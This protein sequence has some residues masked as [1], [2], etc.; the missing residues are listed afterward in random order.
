[1]KRS[2][3]K[4]RQRSASR[5]VATRPGRAVGNP[6]A[7]AHRPGGGGHLG[8]H[9]G[10]NAVTGFSGMTRASAHAIEHRRDADAARAR[11][12][13]ALNR[14][15]KQQGPGGKPNIDP[16]QPML[17]QTITDNAPLT[18][19]NAGLPNVGA[20]EGFGSAARPGRRPRPQG[21]K[22]TQKKR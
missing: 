2:S 11:W 6:L 12:I 17:S 1:M 10:V 20:H 18:G 7:Q 19:I 9:G 5:G 21:G 8:T 15:R 22:F 4:M 14:Q 3:N 13:D 16:G